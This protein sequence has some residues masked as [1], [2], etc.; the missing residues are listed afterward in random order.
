MTPSSGRQ[1]TAAEGP[2]AEGTAAPAAGP[3]ENPGPRRSQDVPAPQ[4]A[5]TITIVALLCYGGVTVL[6]LLGT[7]PGVTRLL[8]CVACVLA[9]F[10]VQMLVSAPRAQIWTPRRKTAALLAQTLLTYLP[11]LWF[12]LNWGS[13]EG[14]LGAS[15]LVLLPSRYGWSLF[16]VV[17]VVTP[18]HALAAGATLDAAS[19]YTI[20]ALLSGLVIYGL[21]RLTELVS[22]LHATRDELARMA[23]G[24]E[25]LRFAR[26]LHD[27]LGYSLSAIVL[28]GTLAHRIGLTQPERARE[29]TREIVDV[30]RQAL[31]DVRLVASSYRALSLTSETRS[32]MS[33]LRASGVHSEVDVA[34][35][36]LPPEVDTFLATV[37]REGV[38]NMLRHSAVRHCTITATRDG[39]TILLSLVNDGVHLDGRE[40]K[41]WGSPLGTERRGNGLDNLHERCV[42]VGGRLKAV[43]RE[44]GLFELEV[45]APVRPAA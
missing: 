22:E 11:L 31:S 7:R 19:Y 8:V 37:V 3:Q 10:T 42:A 25:R 43:V 39:E 36:P 15:F 14:P 44:N 23:V 17:L 32:A 34:C 4:L 27:L 21:A 5:R 20:S 35:G 26:D 41:D 2:E 6:N 28:K 30:A 29:E 9:V 18:L 45:R 40:Q 16:G 1:P 12:G 24:Q 38:T 13:M 33:V